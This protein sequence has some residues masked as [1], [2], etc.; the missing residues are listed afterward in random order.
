M[1]ALLIGSLVLFTACQV[2][3]EEDTQCG[4]SNGNFLN[5]SSCME[6][7]H[8]WNCGAAPS[9]P[10]ELAA[11]LNAELE[12]LHATFVAP[13]IAAAVQLDDGTT[14]VGVVG[15]SDLDGTPL[16]DTA[17]FQLAS[18]S[19]SFVAGLALAL[20]IDLDATIEPWIDH[21]R[22]AEI[23]VRQLLDHSAGVPEYTRTGL[24]RNGGARAWTDPELVALVADAP[25]N[26]EPGTSYG[27]SNTHFV[28]ASMILEAQEERPWQV[29]LQTE[30]LDV[31]GLSATAAPD[32]DEGWGEVVPGFI[33]SSDVTESIH[34]SGIGAAGNLV[35]DA[36]D[37]V[38]WASGLW[39]GALLGADTSL[40]WE[41][42]VN[43]GPWLDYG[44]G[45]MILDD[46]HGMQVAHNG[47]LNGYVS[48]V[49]HRPE[50]G[51]SVAVLANAWLTG[52]PGN[53][54]VTYAQEVA[55]DLWA[56]ALD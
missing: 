10:T 37:A 25:L 44:L 6:A 35:A 27:Y 46:A 40:L 22:A 36:A 34:P 4:C 31:L 23:T 47:A 17:R 49:G 9:F 8:N 43:A 12:T 15:D 14:W 13:G 24:F 32:G 11:E 3:D 29:A 5:E 30:A 1:R 56:V 42:P 7:G 50:E 48:W 16:Q 21:P 33:G 45:T 38:G 28:M 39:G 2:P 55:D 53:P 41:D 26:F 51:I 52:T 20:G 54:D 19:K 18:V